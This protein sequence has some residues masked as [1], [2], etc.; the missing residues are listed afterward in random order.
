MIGAAR[1]GTVR[2]MTFEVHS[3]MDAA[4]V[5]PA[6]ELMQRGVA[7]EDPELR[8]T[9]ERLAACT[10]TMAHPETGRLVPACAQHSVLDVEENAQ[11]RKLLPLT[12]LG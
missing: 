11:L 1:R 2:P 8:A 4:Q 7:A 9:Q 6:W 10:Y 12:V 5:G 3:F